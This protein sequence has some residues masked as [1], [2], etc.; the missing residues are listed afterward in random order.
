MSP[1]SKVPSLLLL[2]LAASVSSWPQGRPP[3]NTLSNRTFQIQ[4][5]LRREE[6]NQTVEMVRVDLKK[7]TGEVVS[8]SFTRSNGEFQ[9][10]G[11]SSGTY[12]LVIEEKGYEPIRE[13]IEII[14]SSRLGV[15]L[16]L[17]RPLELGAPQPG[18]TVSARELTIPRKARE[19]LEKGMGR[20]YDKKD[21]KGSLSFFQRAVTELPSYYEAYEQMGMANMF[22]G[23]TAEAEQ[24]FR[25]S[26]EASENKYAAAYF[27]LASLFSD[28]RRYAEAEPVARQG[29]ALDSSPW[30]GHF[31]LARALLGLKRP[32]DAEKSAAQARTRKP[33]F[34][35]LHLLLANIHIQKHDYPAIVE[36]LDTYLKLVPNGPMSEQARETREKVK[37][38]MARA[39]NTPAAPT[40]P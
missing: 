22:L 39:Q 7:L 26:I 17:K 11:L 32:D 16:F 34:P 29:L 1:C 2:L 4:G 20:L 40:K 21:P 36:D 23:Q 33:D 3:S 30:S 9:F 25:K 24:A 38:I 12:Y 8:T 37:G 27:R 10:A 28:N 15:Y 18:H 31:E 13:A 5:S 6:G 14:N 35:P 19:A